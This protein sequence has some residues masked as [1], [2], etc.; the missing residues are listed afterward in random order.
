MRA[1][2]RGI[3]HSVQPRLVYRPST[4]YTGGPWFG[5]QA[6]SRERILIA[7]RPKSRS[8]WGSREL[9][10]RDASIAIMVPPFSEPCANIAA[11]RHEI[12]TWFL[13]VYGLGSNSDL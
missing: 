5:S 10:F 1:D 4:V 3:V 12:R 6:Q 11:Y 13:I 8:T 7:D 9:G 2:G